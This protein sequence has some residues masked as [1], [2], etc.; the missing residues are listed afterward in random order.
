MKPRADVIINTWV[1]VVAT[2]KQVTD[3]WVSDESIQKQIAVM[4]NAF[5]VRNFQFKLA[6]TTRTVNKD[7]SIIQKGEKTQKLG[8]KF[9]KGDYSTLN[10]YIVKD[11]PG[12]TAGDCSLPQSNPGTEYKFDG[13]RF[14]WDTLP[15]KSNGLVVVHEIGHWL[16]LLHTFQET[17]DGTTA[18]CTHGHGDKVGD[19]PIH[20]RPN[21]VACV[22]VDTCPG[23]KGDDPIHNYMNYTPTS[24]WTNF[25]DGQAK[26]MHSMWKL[27]VSKN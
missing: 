1:H 20:L 12:N 11:M 4:N 13:C 22:P 26:R 21:G 5:K 23:K 15:T 9:R 18:T 3:G 6:G 8:E 17:S 7:L 27:R 2:S 10:L 19:T 16:G 25:S 14:N 24:C